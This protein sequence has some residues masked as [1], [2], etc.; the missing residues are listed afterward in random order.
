MD[1]T[2]ESL[3]QESCEKLFQCAGTV[4]ACDE[5]T[6]D[7]AERL[8]KETGRHAEATVARSL[9]MNNRLFNEER[10]RLEKWAEDMVIAAE[11]DLA[12]TKAQIK[13]I[14]RQSRLVTTLDEQNTLQQKLREVERKQRRQRQQIF[15]IEDQIAEKRDALIDNLQKRMSQKTTRT[16]LF[17][18]RWAVV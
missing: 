7:L 4:T 12:D 10:E 6:P 1:E 14:R 3:D 9:E 13:A 8:R 16:P 2:G 17:I 15:N 11:K 18:I 5:I